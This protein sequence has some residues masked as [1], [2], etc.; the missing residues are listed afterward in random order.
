MRK[1]VQT[2]ATA[3]LRVP[4]PHI[5][6]WFPLIAE[7]ADRFVGPPSG[8]HQVELFGCTMELDTR[9]YMQR[10]YY[11]HCYEAA[12]LAFVE[13][14]LRPGDR[15]IDIGAL[16]GLFAL[17]GARR[18]GPTGR[19]DAFE[20]VPSSYEKL[21]RNIALNGCGWVHPNRAAVT[22]HSGVVSLGIPQERLVGYSVA[23]FSIGA[24]LNAVEAPAVILDEY[25]GDDTPVRLVKID[26]EGSERD[27]LRGASRLLERMPPDALLLELNHEMLSAHGSSITEVL[28]TLT[29]SGYAV[30]TLRRDGRLGPAPTASKVTKAAARWNPD[31][32]PRS[33]L[34]VG[35]ATRWLMF[36]AVGVRRGAP[37]LS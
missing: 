10:R 7:R 29:D 15:M 19:V 8:I 37:K 36:N 14:W 17:V 11:Y 25:V 3:A 22:D 24:K 21:M 27:I 16:V 1:N 34:R 20:P 9:E 5:P 2:V 35:L 30:H 4:G 6:G 31:Q 32:R 23:E 12:E 26:A 13:R 33:R 18:V 28:S